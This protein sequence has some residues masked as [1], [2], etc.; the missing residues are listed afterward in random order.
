MRRC[1]PTG[2]VGLTLGVDTH[3]D[4]HVALALDGVGIEGTGSFVAGLARFLRAE[5]TRVL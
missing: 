4:F 2:A 3:E 1:I 5:E